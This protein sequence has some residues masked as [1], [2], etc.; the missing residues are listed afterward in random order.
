MCKRERVLAGE[1]ELNLEKLKRL[2]KD[3]DNDNN[4]KLRHIM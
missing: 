4:A 2:M 3:K 1:R